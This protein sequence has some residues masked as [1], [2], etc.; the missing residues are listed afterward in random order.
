MDWTLLKVILEG[1]VLLVFFPGA[2]FYLFR[3][4]RRQL[5]DRMQQLED[6]THQ[7]EMKD[8][9]IHDLEAELSAER[10]KFQTFTD[11]LLARNKQAWNRFLEEE[12]AVVRTAQEKGV[13]ALEDEFEGFKNKLTSVQQGLEH[14]RHALTGTFQSFY[15]QRRQSLE[16]RAAPPFFYSELVA[17]FR[18][19]YREATSGEMIPRPG[20]GPTVNR[21]GTPPA[22]SAEE[23]FPT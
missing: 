18:F 12:S 7:L 9:A 10:E 19:K 2:A 20:N 23:S 22:A 5:R 17:E 14:F 16:S 3:V 21:G 15:D 1:V 13:G 11:E 8:R 4:Q 6:Q